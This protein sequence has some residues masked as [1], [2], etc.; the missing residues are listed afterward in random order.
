MLW[1]LDWN[2][3]ARANLERE[4]AA[5]GVDPTRIVWARRKLPAQHMARMQLADLFLDTWPC[6]AHTTASD[7]L[8]AG[9]PVVTFA[10]RTFAS[11]VAASLNHAVGLPELVCDDAA[12][13]ARTV[14]ELAGDP[15]RRAALRQRL[16]AARTG[17]PLFD[18]RRFTRDFEA[19]LLRM[20]QR[21]VEGL[22]AAALP[23]L[24]A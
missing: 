16:V 10:G 8:W 19:L 15:A 7:A 21:H 20:M 23:A 9:V 24:Q 6:N 1:L 14:V 3:Q 11:R 4:A 13:Y 18:S 17:S 5:R 12:H 2:E 22:P